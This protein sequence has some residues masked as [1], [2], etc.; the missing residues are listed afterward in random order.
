M[1]AACHAWGFAEARATGPW[2]LRAATARSARRARFIPA[3]HV[4]DWG[5]GSIT[6]TV[7]GGDLPRLEDVV[8][9]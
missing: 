1:E 9:P 2:L 7:R 8:R 6:L 3:E 4:R 5:P